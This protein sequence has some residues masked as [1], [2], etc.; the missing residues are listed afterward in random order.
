M[1]AVIS[2][3][4]GGDTEIDEINMSKCQANRD[5]GK[6]FY[7]TKF[8]KQAEERTEIKGK[9]KGVV[10]EFMFYE[11]A[12][13]DNRYKTLRFNDYNEEQATDLFYSSK[14]F[15][16]LSDESTKLYTKQWQDIYKMLQEELNKN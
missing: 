2:V 3:Y 9:W 12:F 4:H 8:R 13:K 10:T 7:V 16:K 14:T 11:R 15:G 5:F 1:T 6:G